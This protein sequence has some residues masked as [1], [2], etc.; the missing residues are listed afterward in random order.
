M[1]NSEIYKLRRA[2]CGVFTFALLAG[3]LINQS[4]RAQAEPTSVSTNNISVDRQKQLGFIVV[5]PQGPNDGGD[6]GPHTPGTKTS[7]LQE[8]FDL[9]K[10][11]TQDVYIAGGNLTHGENQGW[12]TFL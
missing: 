1:I 8:A 4:Q 10:R 12:S 3:A 5:T 7:G 2:L 11:T 9:A 6:F